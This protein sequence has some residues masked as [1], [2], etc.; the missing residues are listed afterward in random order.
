MPLFLVKNPQGE[1]DVMW[2]IGEREEHSKSPPSSLVFVPVTC[3]YSL[4]SPF[5]SATSSVFLV[6]PSFPLYPWYLTFPTLYLPSLYRV[7]PHQGR[8]SLLT[9]ARTVLSAVRVPC[10]VWLLHITA[11]NQAYNAFFQENPVFI[12]SLPDIW[13]SEKHFQVTTLCLSVSTAQLAKCHS[14]SSAFTQLDPSPPKLHA[15]KPC[16]SPGPWPLSS[17]ET[18]RASSVCSL[19]REA[20]AGGLHCAGGVGH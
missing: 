13:L 3:S 5:M 20:L 8:G 15:A 17:P 1:Q 4:F 18:L 7:Q 11:I 19:I 9:C 14:L 10:F 2:K 16:V 12:A 6:I